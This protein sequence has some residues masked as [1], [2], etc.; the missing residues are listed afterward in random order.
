MLNCTLFSISDAD[1]AVSSDSSLPAYDEVSSRPSQQVHP[2]TLD[3]GLSWRELHVALGNHPAAHPL[4]FIAG[5]GRP[6]AALDDGARSSGRYFSPA[7]VARI[8]ADVIDV[9]D[10]QLAWGFAGRR[11][12]T[13]SD[14][15]EPLKNLERLR[16]FLAEVVAA[17][18]GIIVHQFA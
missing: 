8:R 4:G 5:G 18:R 17:N 11:L 7:E 14:R 10:E 16:K 6:F 13:N 9:A 12:P 3:L 1:L 2:H 15:T